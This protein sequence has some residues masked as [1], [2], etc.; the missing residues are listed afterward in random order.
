[1]VA[2]AALAIVGMREANKPRAVALIALHGLAGD[3]IGV[4][5][6]AAL[7]QTRLAGG[8]GPLLEIEAHRRLPRLLR[9][10]LEYRQIDATVQSVPSQYIGHRYR[11]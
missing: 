4:R 2:T 1:M 9:R 8:G 11:R 6:P 10:R 7:A 3:V 5:V